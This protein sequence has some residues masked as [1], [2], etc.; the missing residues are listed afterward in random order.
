ME[1]ATGV[2]RWRECSTAWL[3][4][5]G[6][7]FVL[8]GASSIAK[9]WPK[10]VTIGATTLKGSFY[11]ISMGWSQ[12]MKK[13]MKVNATPLP[14][15]GSSAIA[16]LIGSNKLQM[17]PIGSETA[18]DAYFGKDS[19]AKKGKQPIRAIMAGHKRIFQ[20]YVR[21]DSPF[22][23]P[24][25]IRGRRFMYWQAGAPS[26]TNW[27]KLL[28]EAYGIKENEYK[29]MDWKSTGACA[30]A[31]K[32]GRA[33]FGFSGA[34]PNSALL[35]LTRTVGIR[36]IPISE[37]AQK[38][39]VENYGPFEEGVVPK[40][41]YGPGIP[42]EDVRSIR[43]GVWLIA[44]EDLPEDFV[45]EATKAILDHP[46][47]F[48]KY[49]KLARQYTDLAKATTKPV[50]PFHPGAIRYYKEK[51]V[52]TPALEKTQQALLKQGSM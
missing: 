52:W 32:E 19:F 7:A 51:G 49:S 48:N 42:A 50:I 39:I 45:Y 31:I 36:F 47:E 44:R 43:L 35:E 3:L 21:A 6:A 37:K 25:D 26:N 13:Y 5:A 2:K 14:V 15:G 24:E 46:A 30:E 28:V 20:L 4:A 41:I 29:R 23:T 8:Y 12:Q 18:Y 9:D 16:A 1:T 22:K 34:T 33:D 27:G 11:P 17:G 38:Y 40:D 10:E